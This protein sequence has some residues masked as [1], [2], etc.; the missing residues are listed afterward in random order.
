MSAF[1]HIASDKERTTHSATTGP[2]AILKPFSGL[3]YG[4]PLISTQ[5]DHQ[6]SICG[7][8][9]NGSRGRNGEA[10]HEGGGTTIQRTTQA[11]AA[12]PEKGVV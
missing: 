4:H 12:T 11:V 7:A 9:S 6:A 10:E 8:C 1:K 3:L 5:T 2:S